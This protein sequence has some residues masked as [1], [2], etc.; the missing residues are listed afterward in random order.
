MA[1]LRR[2]VV[3]QARAAVFGIGI[4]ALIL[5]TSAVWSDA[6]PVHRS[7]F[8]FVSVVAAQVWLLATGRET[9]REA[10]VIAVFHVV[11]VAMEVF[12]TAVG[13]WHYPEPAFFA[14]GGVPLFTGFMY[15]AVGSYIARFWRLSGMRLERAPPFWVA[16]VLGAAIY[17]NFFTHHYVADIRPGLFAAIVLVYGATMARFGEAGRP[18]VPLLAFFALAA[19]LIYIA[20]NIGSLTGTWLY[21]S[22]ESGWRPVPPGKLGAWFLLMTISFVLVWSIRRDAPAGSPGSAQGR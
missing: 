5:V 14:I 22:Q 21:P 20:E 7:D 9:V 16:A 18:R 19:V 12:K 1:A 4:L 11:G 2:F 10:R 15:S 13:S 6:W 8:I 3:L 17:A